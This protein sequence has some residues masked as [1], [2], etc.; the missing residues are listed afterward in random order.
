MVSNVYARPR[1]WSLLHAHDI[2]ACNDACVC[3]L[4]SCL[5]QVHA[6]S[7]SAETMPNVH[8]EHESQQACRALRKCPV[9][10]LQAITHLL[11]L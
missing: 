8:A 5:L 4:Q 7:T 3:C 1:A 10:F 9:L 11:S 6:W 2:A